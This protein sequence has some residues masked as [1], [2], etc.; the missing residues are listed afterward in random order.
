MSDE[1]NVKDRLD[2]V[3]NVCLQDIADVGHAVN[4]LREHRR[5]TQISIRTIETR[6]AG[7]EERLGALQDMWT[8]RVTPREWQSES[9]PIALWMDGKRPSEPTPTRDESMP[10]ASVLPD[11]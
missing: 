3:R 5:L 2:A 4:E 7:I 1:A 10:G 9:K 11:A 8:G 6:L